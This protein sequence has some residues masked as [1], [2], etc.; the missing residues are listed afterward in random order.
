M[1]N[2]DRKAA[3]NY[4]P[5]DK[6]RDLD[7]MNR[8]TPQLTFSWDEENGGYEVTG[9]STSLHCRPDPKQVVKSHI[10]TY[11]TLTLTQRL[12]YP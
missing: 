4:A 7:R 8:I 9:M 2:P 5:P 3:F 6:P 12:C 1:L 10:S 11:I